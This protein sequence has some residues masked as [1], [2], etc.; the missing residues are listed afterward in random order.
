MKNK[1][2]LILFFFI[3]YHLNA[4]NTYM[5]SL[6]NRLNQPKI[7]LVEKMKTYDV[8]VEQYRTAMMY[9]KAASINKKYL[10]LAKQKKEHTEI[11]KAY[12]NEGVILINQ[13]KYDKAEMLLDSV[14]S[15]ASKTNDKIAAAYSVYFTLYL[16]KA[17]GDYKK[18]MNYGLNALSLLEETK[19]NPL[20]EF[21]INYQ[22]YGIYT[23][24]NDLENSKKYAQKAIEA[25]LKSGNKNDLSNSYSAM[26]VAFTYQYEKSKSATDFQA[27]L[28][29]SEKAAILYNQ[30]PGQVSGYTYSIA[31][32]NKASYLLGYSPKITPEIRNQIEYNINESLHIS[33]KLPLAQATQTASLG[34]LS[35][36]AKHDGDWDKAEAYL[37]QAYSVML[38]QNPIYYHIMSRVVNDLSEVYERKGDL[39]KA[40]EFQKKYIEYRALLFNQSEAEAVKKLEVQYQ[41]EKKER[42]IQILKE[43]AENQRKQKL[44][45][46]GLGFIGL[47]GAFFMFRSY[48]FRLR[49]SLEQKKKLTTEK[50]E[51]ELQIKFEKEEQS[52][53]KIEQQLLALQQQKLQDEVM[54]NQLHIQ[55][56]NDILK[57]LKDRLETDEVVNLKQIIRDENLLDI[58]FEK[59]K[60]QIKEIHPNF[61]QIISK[62][63]K[64]K[65][66][67]LDL[68][69][70]AYFYLGMD[71]KQI[72]NIL[73]VEP[74]SVRMT[75]YRL[76]QKLGLDSATNLVEYLK[77]IEKS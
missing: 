8:L 10:E 49:Y 47:V 13:E 75:K 9:D 64:Q 67:S 39:K 32:N 74:K 21:K 7:D 4:Q 70:C 11:T 26:A 14:K 19:G 61:F 30:F 45:Y 36:L 52:R 62:H 28:D 68:K 38:T 66:T 2:L 43:R 23:E 3:F 12:V 34:M 35:N 31:R 53:L 37:L 27:I 77:H 51:A 5:D 54:A 17:L 50:H 57:Q 59:A 72:A 29:Y 76:K 33:S 73:N 6:N 58:D 25:A 46:A 40:L 44:L 42:E 60:F 71:T 1:I 24:W 55:H 41:S 15:S 48:H 65:L 18:A 69:Y 56:K 22:L 16:S 20:L 63:A